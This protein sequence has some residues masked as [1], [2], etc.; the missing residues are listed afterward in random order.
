MITRKFV[1]EYNAK[2]IM[3]NLSHLGKAYHAVVLAS[4]EHGISI[5]PF[6]VNDEEKEDFIKLWGKKSS[7]TSAWIRKDMKR[8]EFCFAHMSKISKLKDVRKVIAQGCFDGVYGTFTSQ[9]VCPFA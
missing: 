2:E 3:W 8:P 6:F 9:P 1:A 5:K 4:M 7:S